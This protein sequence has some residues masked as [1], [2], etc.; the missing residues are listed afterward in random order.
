MKSV[1]IGVA[2]CEP[3]SPRGWLSSKPT[4][5]TASTSGVKPTNQ[6]SRRSLV[7]PDLPAASSVN[8]APRALAP[9]PSLM[10]LRIMCVTRYV[11][12]GR[13]TSGPFRRGGCRSSA[14]LRTRVMP[15]SGAIV[16]PLPNSV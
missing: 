3:L 9:V 11:V 1:Q 7:V 8:P 16:P 2:A 14:P 6:A 10:T 15:V 12:S 13:A 5:T 4:Q